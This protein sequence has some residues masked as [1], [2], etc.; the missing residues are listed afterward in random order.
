MIARISEAIA[1]GVCSDLSTYHALILTFTDPG[2]TGHSRQRLL[3]ATM[4]SSSL[5]S[6]PLAQQRL[7][8]AEC[9]D[10]GG[11]Q[12][13]YLLLQV[14]RGIRACCSRRSERAQLYECVCVE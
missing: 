2:S 11:R 8:S 9:L 7:G 6:R 12:A 1:L 4:S 10:A 5:L 13:A 3:P 14:A